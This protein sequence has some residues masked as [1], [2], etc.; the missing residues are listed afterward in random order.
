MGRTATKQV[1]PIL[2]SFDTVTASVFSGVCTIVPP[3]VKLPASLTFNKHA[4]HA[5]NASQINNELRWL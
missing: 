5:F 2:A 1:E 3:A 4:K